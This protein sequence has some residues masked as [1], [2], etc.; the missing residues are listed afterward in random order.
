M[1]AES[2]EDSTN[3]YGIYLGRCNHEAH[4]ISVPPE[5]PGTPTNLAVVRFCEAAFPHA[6][7]VEAYLFV[8]RHRQEASSEHGFTVSLI[9]AFGTGLAKYF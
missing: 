1:P 4:I 6:G 9:M 7:E 8:H 2:T 5:P 3:R